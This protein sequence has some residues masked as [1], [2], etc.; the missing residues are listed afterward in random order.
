MAPQ[1]EL[2]QL[3][4]ESQDGEQYLVASF[5]AQDDIDLSYLSLSLT[6]LRASDLRAAGAW[7]ARPSARP[8]CA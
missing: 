7:S 2:T 4:I 8:S 3:A 1:L 6:G 5:D